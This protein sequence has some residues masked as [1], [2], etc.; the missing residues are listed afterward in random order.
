MS[1]L[2]GGPPPQFFAAALE[3]WPTEHVPGAGKTALVTGSSGGIGFYVARILGRCGYTVIVPARPGFEDD[4]E[5]AKEGILRE[6][7]G[8]NVIVPTTKLDLTSLASC[9]EFGAAM[10]AEND[11]LEVLCLNAGRGGAKGD[12]RDEKDGMESVMLT[13]VYGHFTLAAALMPLLKAADAARIVTQSSGA[14]F[15]A[16]PSKLPDLDGTDAANFNNF[17][18]YCL[19]KAACV[20]MTQALNDRLAAT[21]SYSHI[22]CLA[23]DPGLTSTGVNIQHQLTTSAELPGGAGMTSTNQLHDA[24]GHHAADGALAMGLA[25]V[26]AEPGR[27]DFYTAMGGG[28]HTGNEPEP[29]GAALT[30][31]EANEMDPLVSRPLPR[32]SRLCTRLANL[33]VSTSEHAEL[34]RRLARSLLGSGDR[35]DQR[36]LRHFVLRQALAV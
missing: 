10:C 1:E 30:D 23:T 25:S 35:A 7:P 31:P 11:S 18:Q 9:R 19:S 33:Q 12:P 22:V 3:S 29:P 4:A 20:L 36:R 5:G 17:D 14:R 27:N 8:A 15:R 2:W 13:N 34:A 21:P 28:R 32:L 6:S 16:F 24:M 26:V